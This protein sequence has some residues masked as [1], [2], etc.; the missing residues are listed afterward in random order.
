MGFVSRGPNERAA[1]V[2]PAEGRNA[3]V[4]IRYAGGETFVI[5]AAGRRQKTKFGHL[6]QVTDPDGRTHGLVLRA[7]DEP[8]QP[9]RR[10]DDEAETGR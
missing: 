8:P 1:G 7:Y 2:V 9:L 10:G 3:A 4:R 6:V 5:H